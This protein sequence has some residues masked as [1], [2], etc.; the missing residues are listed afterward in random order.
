MESPLKT[1][2]NLSMTQYLPSSGSSSPFTPKRSR[3]KSKNSEEF[4]TVSRVL[5]FDDTHIPSPNNGNLEFSPLS[6]QKL[7]PLENELVKVEKTQ[8]IYQQRTS[9]NSQQTTPVKNELMTPVKSEQT[10][11]VKSQNLSILENPKI[12]LSPS[13]QNKLNRFNVPDCDKNF[14]KPSPR[15]RGGSN[16]STPSKKLKANS[17]QN[18]KQITE[19]FKPTQKKSDSVQSQ[20]NEENTNP[21]TKNSPFVTTNICQEES[22][23][24]STSEVSN[25]IQSFNS[26]INSK[27]QKNNSPKKKVAK[28]VNKKVPVSPF[29]DE[30]KKKANMRDLQVTPTKSEN[31]NNNINNVKNS[32]KFF[33][34]LTN[35]FNVSGGDTYSRFIRKIVMKPEVQCLGKNDILQKITNCTDDE[36]KIYG[37]LFSRKHDWIRF[38]EPD[39]LKKYKEL[40]FCK[41]FDNVL[42]SL[43]TKQL[44][45]TGKLL[46]IKYCETNY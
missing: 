45:K 46:L 8:V 10:T 7:I 17:I 3:I 30:K 25:E 24:I 1:P 33:E 18:C 43:A 36:L 22:I 14:A 28:N 34:L 19:Y 12:L 35:K 26:S 37:R 27:T 16:N 9:V 4:S 2:S 32:P 23:N 39:G 11:P 5:A 42:T 38:N 13:I 6:Q 15:K 31:V 40:N 41:D 20:N 44:I 29:S 21:K